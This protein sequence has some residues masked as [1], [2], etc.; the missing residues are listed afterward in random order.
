M[1]KFRGH[2]TPP[3]PPEKEPMTFKEVYSRKWRD[4]KSLVIKVN[5]SQMDELSFRINKSNLELDIIGSLESYF[6]YSVWI[7]DSHS[8]A[9]YSTDILM[10]IK[11]FG[12][13]ELIDVKIEAPDQ[14][15]LKITL[16][17]EL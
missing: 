1:F 10:D 6:D 14:E 15:V 12:K 11:D 17:W 13:K 4:C 8:L 2:R 7:G 9:I 5:G 16:V 3:P